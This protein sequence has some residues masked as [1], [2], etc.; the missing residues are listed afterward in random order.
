MEK[1]KG[2]GETRIR[3]EDKQIRQ[4]MDK[5]DQA[6]KYFSKTL[7]SVVKNEKDRF[8]KSSELVFMALRLADLSQ[9]IRVIRNEVEAM[10]LQLEK[11]N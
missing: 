6:Q 3:E 7:K 1:R 4:D 11:E 8:V 10:T 5:L 2:R 9:A